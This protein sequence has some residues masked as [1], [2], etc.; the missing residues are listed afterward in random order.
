VYVE[1]DIPNWGTLDACLLRTERELLQRPPN[2]PV[3]LIV[4]DSVTHI[5]RDAAE[6]GPGVHRP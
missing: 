6:F 2:R 4:L 1:R 3:R 5:F